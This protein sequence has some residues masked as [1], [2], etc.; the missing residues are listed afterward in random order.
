M[1]L[2]VGIGIINLPP[3]FLNS[4]RLEMISS[5][6]FQANKSANSI[7]C[8]INSESSTTGM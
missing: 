7:F 2:G 6:N 4:E 1:I 3:L 8:F 5:E